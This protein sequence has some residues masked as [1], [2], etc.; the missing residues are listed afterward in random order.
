MK[1][2]GKG[3]GNKLA[4]ILSLLISYLCFGQEYEVSVTTVSVWVKVTKKSGESVQN[5]T[6][7]DFEVSEDKKKVAITCFEETKIGLAS[8]QTQQTPES[9]PS[10]QT[11]EQDSQS[12]RVVLFLDL[13][14]TSQPEY[15][16][17]K[18]KILE[19][20]NRTP[21][22]WTFMVAVLQPQGLLQFVI[23][24][25]SDVSVV[26]S[27]LEKL[28]ANAK[29]DIS[30]LNNR[31]MIAT[32]LETDVGENGIRKACQLARRYAAEERVEINFSIQSL[33]AFEKYITNS[34]DDV[35]TV[36]A[37]VSGGINARPGQQYFDL[38]SG[39]DSWEFSKSYPE[40][41]PQSG[42]DIEKDLRKLI[43]R[44]N[45][46]NMTFYTINSR[47]MVNPL[48]DTSGESSRRI[49]SSDFEF[50]KYYQD[51]MFQMANETGG[52]A[53]DNSLNFKFGFNQI[54]QDLN[55]QY[56]ICY[57]APGH[58]K[59]GEYHEIKVKCKQ[60]DTLLRYRKGYS[61]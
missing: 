15:L 5:L 24:K 61:D 34:K 53:F 23:P 50:H 39:G 19:F 46:H 10:T 43:A 44:M 12:K 28:K 8:L 35:H 26:A 60:R 37:F 3:S 17:M 6:A 51:L 18:T 7:D 59:P 33:D 52:L 47:G 11:A 22:Q 21:K 56:L 45:R 41:E 16:F 48:L 20:I 9:F 57:N 31:R 49:K 54:V 38:I 58:K 36:V 1:L 4:L 27:S 29:R 25:T 30:Q 40:C 55:H 13:F 14:N 2:P 42:S 32:I